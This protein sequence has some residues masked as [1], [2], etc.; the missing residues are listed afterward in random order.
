MKTIK[1]T[2]Q[3]LTDLSSNR[4]ADGVPYN[5]DDINILEGKGKFKVKADKIKKFI[6]E[7]E[8]KFNT[9]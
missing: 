8:L 3:Q 2:K 9:K 1:L 5:E 7:M 6:A 4:D